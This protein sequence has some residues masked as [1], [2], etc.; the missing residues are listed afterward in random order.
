MD[1]TQ[2]HTFVLCAYGESPYLE[3]CVE[4]LTR[5]TLRSHILIS[6]STPNA[7]IEG[8]AARYGIP[9]FVN[10]GE[11]GITGDW[12][13]A[14]A[15]ADTPYVTI[16]HQDDLYEPT[17]TESVLRKA[18]KSKRP[19]LIFT[20]YFEIRNGE[21]VYKNKLLRI[22]RIMN[23]GF[24]LFPRSRWARLRVL[25]LGNSICCPAV[26]YAADACKDFRFDGS[27]QFACDWDAWDR[28][29]RR[30]GAFLYVGEP[31]VGHRIHEESETTKQTATDGRAREEYTMF[32]RYWG[33]SMARR[34]SKFYAKGADSNQL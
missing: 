17:Y 28:L 16:A 4:S 12:N 29:A 10:T 20:E 1:K 18:Q 5:Q 9:L 7:L 26:T 22:K 19:I 23:L 15:Q 33:E 34:L 24:R 21:R 27:F 32:R 13:F 6:T 30:K 14:V 2:L 3:A 25:S 8:I 31:L 11:K